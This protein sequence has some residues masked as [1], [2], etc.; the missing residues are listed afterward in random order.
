MTPLPVRL[1]SALT[2]SL[3]L[4]FACSALF[5]KTL[6]LF[7][8]GLRFA[9]FRSGG[10]LAM[11]SATRRALDTP[12]NTPPNSVGSSSRSWAPWQINANDREGRVSPSDA[13]NVRRGGLGSTVVEKTGRAERASLEGSANVNNVVRIKSETVT[14]QRPNPKAYWDLLRPHNIPWSFGLVAAGSLVA[15]HNVGS[16]LDPKVRIYWLPAQIPQQTAVLRQNK[17]RTNLQQL[18]SRESSGACWVFKNCPREQS[19]ICSVR[20]VSECLPARR[21]LCGRRFAS[22]GTATEPAPHQ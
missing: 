7:C 20:R 15:S 13:G 3:A 18:K 14:K 10:A 16:L 2:L 21:V 8:E 22:S 12:P 1:A 9:S 19:W 6:P 11:G 5:T 4:T 17:T